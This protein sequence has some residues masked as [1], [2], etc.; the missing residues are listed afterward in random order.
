MGSVQRKHFALLLNEV[1]LLAEARCYVKWQIFGHQNNYV[2]KQDFVK[3]STSR[4][5]IKNN[6]ICTRDKTR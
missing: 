4:E 5:L 3:Q 2:M 1:H 6:T